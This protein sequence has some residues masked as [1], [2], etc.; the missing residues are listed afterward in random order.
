[1]KTSAEFLSNGWA[2]GQVTWA[3][4]AK[5]LLRLWCHSQKIH[6]P[7]RNNFLSLR[8]RRLAE[9]FKGFN[10]SLTQPVAL[11]SCSCLQKFGKS[12]SMQWK[13]NCLFSVSGI[14]S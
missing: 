12:L 5:K 10:S 14:I 8:A 13:K 4:M 3:K 2:L 11:R 9:S 6:N 7:Q 1:M